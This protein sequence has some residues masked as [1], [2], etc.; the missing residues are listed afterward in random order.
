MLTCLG[1]MLSMLTIRLVPA[2]AEWLGWQWGFLV[3]AP[4]PALGVLAMR[5]LSRNP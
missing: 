3:L 2:A 1:F 5:A 4:G